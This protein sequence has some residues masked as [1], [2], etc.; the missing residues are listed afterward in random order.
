[1]SM[2][3]LEA[4]EDKLNGRLTKLFQLAD[5]NGDGHVTRAELSEMLARKKDYLKSIPCW[6]SAFLLDEHLWARFNRDG[7]AYLELHEFKD[8]FAF[9]LQVRVPCVLCGPRL[10]LPLRSLGSTSNRLVSLTS[11]PSPPPCRMVPTALP[12]WTTDAEG[13]TRMKGLRS[14]RRAYLTQ[15]THTYPRTHVNIRT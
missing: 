4:F 14:T 2:L 8:I 7:D 12:T 15:H 5:V 10:R 1:M 9:E 6:S 13:E 3:S 11:E